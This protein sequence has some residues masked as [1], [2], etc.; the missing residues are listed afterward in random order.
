MEWLSEFQKKVFHEILTK[1]SKLKL[2]NYLKY[3]PYKIL[4]FAYSF[5]CK[6]NKI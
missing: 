5:Y 3:I 1:L 4:D 2:D 6:V